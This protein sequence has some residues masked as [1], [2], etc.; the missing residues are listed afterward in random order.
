MHGVT[1]W[2]LVAHIAVLGYWLGAELVINSTYRYVCY[3]ADLPFADR[4]R[5][6]DHVMNVD[7]HVRYALVLQLALG[8][9]LAARYGFVSGGDALVYAAAGLGL[10]WLGLVEAVHRLRHS[11]TGAWL[12]RLDRW[13]RYG[14]MVALL[15]VAFSWLGGQW[16]LPDWLRLKLGLFAGVA[17]CGVGIRL[18]LI[19]HFRVWQAM[20]SDGV[21]AERNRQVRQIYRVATSVLVGLWAFIVAIVWVSVVKP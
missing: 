9:M 11:P 14:L 7:Q 17:A 3:A 4:N 1:T 13:L 5:L 6:M 15:G 8:T 19:R 12:A 10:A 21:T 18:A 20:A 2:L 16:P